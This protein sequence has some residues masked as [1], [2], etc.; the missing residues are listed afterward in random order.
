MYTAGKEGLDRA[1]AQRLQ[2]QL[3]E[4]EKGVRQR[5]E[6]QDAEFALRLSGVATATVSSAPTAA[7]YAYAVED[8]DPC[9]PM[10]FSSNVLK[11]Q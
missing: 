2:R 9:K 6:A 4:E 5:Q 7:A 8:F 3:D 11:N 10:V 1:Y